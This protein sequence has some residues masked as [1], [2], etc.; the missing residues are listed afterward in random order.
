MSE[1]KKY[2]LPSL[3]YGYGDL[4]PHISE[5]QLMIHHTK[6][7]A[8]YV[9]GANSVF[10][11]LEE[12]R[13]NKADIDQKSIL[14]ELSF[15]VGG[16]K[17]HSLF[18]ENLAPSDNGGGGEPQGKLGEAINRDFGDFER[19]KKEFSAAVASI[20][21]SGWGALVYDEESNKLIISQIEKH[22]LNMYPNLPILM[23]LDFWEHAFYIDYKNEKVKFIEVFW[24]IVNWK[25]IEERFSEILK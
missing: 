19:F 4:N 20:E 18:W 12:A 16:H 1:E 22:N 15:H 5:E 9:K 24:N 23:V 8:A 10:L 6:H 13:E 25:K 2:T 14:K 17:L 3:S 7:H 21:G 11:K